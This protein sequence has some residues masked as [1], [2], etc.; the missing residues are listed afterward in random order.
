MSNDP[1]RQ[2]M[3]ALRTALD[4]NNRLKLEIQAALSKTF[5]DFGVPVSDDLF[6]L[7]TPAIPEEIAGLSI[8]S[9]PRRP[10]LS[11]YSPEP[12]STDPDRI[13]PEPPS[14]DPAIAPEPPSTDPER[15][16]PEPPSTDPDR[17][18]PEPPST[19]PNQ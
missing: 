8:H 3:L 18:A 1:I 15:L 11:T 14:T 6:R 16:V 5:R 17:I 12:P 4:L 9:R 2:E 19:D 10:E 13:A 7:L